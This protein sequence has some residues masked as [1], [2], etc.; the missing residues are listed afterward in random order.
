MTQFHE[1]QE[2]EVVQPTNHPVE[3]WPGYYWRKAKIVRDRAKSGR[4]PEGY[5]VVQ[6]PDGAR[7]V[8]D[9]KHIRV[10]TKFVEIPGTCM[11]STDLIQE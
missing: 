6:F 2:V 3:G 1:G 10:I 11:Q 5:E 4:A 7:A 8:F 9:A